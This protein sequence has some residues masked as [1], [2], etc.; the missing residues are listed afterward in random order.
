MHNKMKTLNSK[1]GVLVL[2]VSG[3]L[4]ISL[5]N[6][7]HAQQNY[8]LLEPISDTATGAVDFAT[9]MKEMFIFLV[10]LAVMSSVIMLVLAAVE[11]SASGASEAAKKDATD[12]IQNTMIGLLLAL[13][14][15]LILNVIN[16]NLVEFKL[17]IP[18][19]VLS[20]A[21]ISS[22]VVAPGGGSG[23]VEINSGSRTTPGSTTKVP[24]TTFTAQ[25]TAAREQL[26]NLDSAITINNSTPCPQGMDY[27]VYTSTTGG[28]CTTLQGVSSTMISGVVNVHKI[29][30]CEI[31]INGG[32]ELGHSETGGHA[33]GRAVDLS[34]SISTCLTNY[35]KKN[36][37]NRY[38]TESGYV[39]YDTPVGKMQ[40]E[41]NTGHWHYFTPA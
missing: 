2:L 8:T 33:D 37:T 25:E 39:I 31:Q 15:Y 30:G 19:V 26:R 21:D 18:K 3:I 34:S 17:T 14:A 38:T 5:P 41:T 11:Y 12:R 32:S 24:D 10:G 28:H 7:T 22:S 23:S 35:I 29:T 6:I 16:P 36:Y 20:A 9:Y 27:K 13:G 1:K 40:D 4:F